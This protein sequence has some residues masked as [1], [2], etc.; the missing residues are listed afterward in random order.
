MAYNPAANGMIKRTQHSLKAALIAC[1][2]DKN[3]NALLP[4]VLLGLRTVPKADGDASPAEKVFGETL[5]VPREFFPLS[6]GGTDTP[7]PR[8]RELSRKFTPCHRAFTDRTS[9]C[10]PPTLDSCAYVFVTVDARQTPLTRPYR[11]PHKVIRRAPKAFLL[12][13]HVLEDWVTVDRLK[14][15]FLLDNEISEGT[16]RRPR[17]TP[18]QHSTGTAAPTP[19]RGPGQPTPKPEVVP[20][21]RPQFS[22]SRGP[23]QLPQH[24]RD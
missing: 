7:L 15:A 11:G 22:R 18:Q 23:L 17:V 19:K 8:L 3:W 9:R 2:T 1:C 16:G 12:D 24:L 4:W 6:A 14:P 20:T 21:P 10:N 13:I 5:V